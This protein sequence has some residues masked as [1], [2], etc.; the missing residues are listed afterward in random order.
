[1][2]ISLNGSTWKEG[3][4]KNKRNEAARLRLQKAL[5]IE[6]EHLGTLW[7]MYRKIRQG[8]GGE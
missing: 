5:L 1:M 2:P 3:W 8:K 7:Q 6:L 4:M